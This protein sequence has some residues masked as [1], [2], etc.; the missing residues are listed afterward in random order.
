MC[1]HYWRIIWDWK[2]SNG[3][4]PDSQHIYLKSVYCQGAW[5]NLLRWVNTDS[6]LTN[7]HTQDLSQK[8]TFM[9]CDIT[10]FKRVA[11]MLKVQLN[12]LDILVGNTGMTIFM[13]PVAITNRQ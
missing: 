12:R 8:V 11:D 13:A 2:R 9:P 6:R 4:R 7:S 3:P 5:G 10:L 1:C